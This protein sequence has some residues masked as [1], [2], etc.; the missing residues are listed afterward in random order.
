MP[1]RW[2]HQF[3]VQ[4]WRRSCPGCVVSRPESGW[5]LPTAPPHPAP[6]PVGLSGSSLPLRALA[7]LALGRWLLALLSPRNSW[8][9]PRHLTT[10][11][12]QGSQGQAVSWSSSS[13]ALSREATAYLTGDST[14]RV[15]AH[16]R[17][18]TAGGWS[19]GDSVRFARISI[20]GAGPV[21]TPAVWGTG[22]KPCVPGP[23]SGPL[24]LPGGLIH[25]RGRRPSASLL[26]WDPCPEP[27]ACAVLQNCVCSC[28]HPH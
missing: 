22:E 10:P 17:A 27:G 16:P 25:R 14:A 2:P 24:L 15:T 7:V 28:G 12:P 3:S 18:H 13:Q 8:F 20:V 26:P 23:V 11:C 1:Q 21:A 4:A 19:T 9:M 5:R 6:V